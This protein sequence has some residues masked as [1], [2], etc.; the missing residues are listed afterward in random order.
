MKK[1]VYILLTLT[2]AFV[3][4]YTL[5]KNKNEMVAEAAIAD[6]KS[7]AISVQLTNPVMGKID[8]SFA[9]Q[10]NFAPV[11]SLAL[12]SETQGQIL[13]VL[14][15][16][17]DRV[18]R[19]DVLIQVEANTLQAEFQMAEANYEKAKRDLGRF[20]NLA[21]GE[22]ITKR[23]LEEAR[24]ALTTAASQ[25]TLAKQRLAKATIYAPID[26]EID[27]MHIEIGSY[28]GIATKLYDIVNV[29]RLKLLVKVNA[30]EVVLIEK[31]DTVTINADVINHNKMKGTI[32]SIAAQADP[33]FKYEVELEFKNPTGQGI[34][35]G[36]YGTANFDIEEKLDVMLVPREAIVGSLQNPTVYV[37]KDSISELVSIKIGRVMQNQ[38]EVLDG[39]ELGQQIV[40]SGQIN[41]R[42]GSKVIAL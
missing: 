29:D 4:V 14:K 41:L 40:Q 35:A 39:L 34:R 38:V 26:G 13:K 8:R 19:G 33:S 28:L 42:N 23:Q 27:E 31:G 21:Q 30:S 12:L 15:R 17:G 7:D 3:V 11:Q 25:L 5:N 32:T 2:I 20:E 16:K 36:M 37:V 1:I 10:G 9:A 6:I 18:R 24:L 22:A